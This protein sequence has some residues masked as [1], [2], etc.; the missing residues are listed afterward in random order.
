LSA[1]LRW[2]TSVPVIISSFV[3][4]VLIGLSFAPV[5]ALIDGKLLDMIATGEAARVRL[6][7]MTA[8]QKTAHFWASVLNDTAYPIAYGAFFAG[9]AGRFA[10][11]RFRSWVMLPALVTAIVDLG[12]NTVQALALSGGADLLGL[13]TVLTP[14][15]FG[16]FAFAA[17]LA[18]GLSLLALVRWIMRRGAGAR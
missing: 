8:V 3:L 7:E 12:E 6:G 15:K 2:L 11:A 10:P 1:L 5:Q 18:L 16:L 4:M 13:K 14:L 17:L 9:L